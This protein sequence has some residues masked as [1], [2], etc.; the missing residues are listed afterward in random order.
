MI[1]TFS[2]NGIQA[3]LKQQNCEFLI[4]FKKKKK[5]NTQN[6]YRQTLCTIV[7]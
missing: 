7:K 4:E 5:K 3:I 6:G 2:W 1:A